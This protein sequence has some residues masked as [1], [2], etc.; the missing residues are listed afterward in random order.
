MLIEERVKYLEEYLEKL[1]KNQVFPGA[2]FGIVTPE[3]SYYN[4]LGNAQITPDIEKVKEDTIYDLASLTK[5]VATTTA[6]MILIEKGYFTLDTFVSDLLP[7]YQNRGVK[8]KHL[9]THT[10]GHDADIDCKKMNKEELV[11]AIYNSKIDV[12][13]F[14]REVLYSD[15]GYIVLGYIVEEITGSLEKFVQENVFEPLNMKETFYN[16]DEKYINRCATTE[17]CNMRERMI[18]GIVHDEKSYVLGGVAGHAG[19]FSTV[20]DLSKFIKMYLNDG[21]Y[22]GKQ[23]LNK[24]TIDVMAKCHTKGLDSERGLGWIVKGENNVLCDIASDKTIYH[25]GFTGTSII[26]DLEYKKGFVLLTNRVHPSREN[27]KLVNLR[28]NIA[29]IAFSSIK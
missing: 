6:I 10:S 25:S 15:I 3:E 26:I 20:G 24:Q 19:L 14:E 8:V 29:N 28:R 12:N 27:N 22:D 11:N 9:L 2:C 21:I 23:I 5:V 17:Y 13:R 18:K 4:Y 1:C 7:R 16:P